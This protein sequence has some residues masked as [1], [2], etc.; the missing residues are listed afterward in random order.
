MKLKIIWPGRTKTREWRSLQDFYLGRIRRLGPCSL[1]ETKE[2]K[3]L[4]DSQAEKIKEIEARHL[5][6]HFQDDYIICLFDK[7]REMDSAELAKFLGKQAASS[8]RITFVVGGFAGL[9]Q[10]ILKR[11]DLV[12]SLSRLTFSHELCRV[13]LLEQIYRALTILKGMH[14]AK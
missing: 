11:A 5:E 8:R 12:L 4:E 6:K 7:G 9:A 14:Y 13:V 2:V 1:V 10:R 3:G